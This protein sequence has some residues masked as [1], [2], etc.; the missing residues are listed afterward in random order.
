[1]D[2]RDMHVCTFNTFTHVCIGGKWVGLRIWVSGSKER[3]CATDLSLNFGNLFLKL[4]N[5]VRW[6]W[7]FVWWSQVLSFTT[8]LVFVVVSRR[9]MIL[10]WQYLVMHLCVWL[11]LYLSI[12]VFVY[13]K[14]VEVLYASAIRWVENLKLEWVVAWSVRYRLIVGWSRGDLTSACLGQ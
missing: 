3:P 9:R 7:D 10:R 14:Q 1:M 5:I 12:C 4:K 6:G 8:V 11:F 13:G 2:F